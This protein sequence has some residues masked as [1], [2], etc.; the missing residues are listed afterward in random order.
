[1]YFEIFRK[2]KAYKPLKDRLGRSWALVTVV[3]M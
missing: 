3:N 2:K 1:M